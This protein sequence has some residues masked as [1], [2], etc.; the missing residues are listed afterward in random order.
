[1]QAPQFDHITSLMPQC[2]DMAGKFFNNTLSVTKFYDEYGPFPRGEN[3]SDG[4]ILPGK[5]NAT[6]N[7]KRMP[8]CT[9]AK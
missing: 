6:L 4:D 9:D 8:R 7:L 5:T 2:F 3:E 1:V